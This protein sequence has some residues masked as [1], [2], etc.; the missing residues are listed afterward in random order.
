MKSQFSCLFQMLWKL[1]FVTKSISIQEHKNVITGNEFPNWN[2]ILCAI[3]WTKELP[4]HRGMRPCYGEVEEE[5]EEI[6]PALL[7]LRMLLNIP[8]IGKSLVDNRNHF[9]CSPGNSMWKL[10]TKWDVFVCA[11]S[12]SKEERTA[13]VYMR[14]ESPAGPP[15]HISPHTA[16]DIKRPKPCFSP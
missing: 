11:G 14:P 10:I 4:T 7:P 13:R 5:D 9:K 6:K 15:L 12:C 3:T 8:K 16:K 1:P 2:S